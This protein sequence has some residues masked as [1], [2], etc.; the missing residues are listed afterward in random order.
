MC[1]SRLFTCVNQPSDIEL[2]QP[3]QRLE[4]VDLST[5]DTPTDL[6]RAFELQPPD[7]VVLDIDLDTM[8]TEAIIRVMGEYRHTHWALISNGAPNPAWNARVQ[9]C[10]ATVFRRP[11]DGKSVQTL[12]IDRL[13]TRFVSH[14]TAIPVLKSQANQYG[15][16]LGSSE[17]MRLLYHRLQR[18][19]PTDA[20]VLI[21]GA[22]GVGKEH[23][24]KTLHSLSQ[25]AA[26]PF[27]AI[28]CGALS[29]EL[30]ESE[31]FGHVKGA[32][33]GAHQD[34]QGIFYQ[35]EGG[36]VFL[37]E[38]TE[39]PQTLQVKLLRVLESGEYR[40]VGATKNQTA[41]VRLVAATNRDTDQ[42]IIQEKLRE[43]IYYRLAQFIVTV[44]PLCER[45]DDIHALITHFL[46]ELNHHY[47]AQTSLSAEALSVLTQHRWPGNVRELKH[48]VEHGFLLSSGHIEVSDLPT[49]VVRKDDKMTASCFIPEGMTLSELEQ[50]AIKQSL[51]RYNGNRQRT[52]AAL[53]I[54][55]KTLYNKLQH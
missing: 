33:T 43:D 31:L 24:A 32:F 47:N 50:M 37:D 17:P 54:S 53:G 12:L 42:A 29:P 36:T 6:L 34:H 22:S 26:A 10:A 23:V 25:Q 13:D 55:P 40:P 7:W 35:A 20:N 28:N 5:F 27:M 48:A 19:G 16:L 39:M 45:G 30:I 8:C 21:V 3:A 52:A 2:L 11:L 49:T 14:Q 9:D 38:I 41:N 46:A 1:K 4:H 18:L 51:A 44:P 15:Y